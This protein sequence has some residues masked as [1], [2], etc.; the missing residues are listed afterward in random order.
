MRTAADNSGIPHSSPR[1]RNRLLALEARMLFDGAAPAVVDKATDTRAGKE[2]TAV[3]I[4]NL[5]ITDAEHDNQTVTLTATHGK[6]AIQTPGLLTIA[7]NNTSTVTL[8]GTLADVNAALNGMMFLGDQDFNGIASFTVKTSDGTSTVTGTPI[9]INLSPVNDA[10]TLSGGSLT[11]NE[12]GSVA[13]D[14]AVDNASG[15]GFTDAQLGL[16]DVDNTQEQVI[17]KITGLAQHGTLSLDGVQLTVG[18]TFSASQLG[19]LTYTHDGTQVTDPAGIM[20]AITV[21]IDDGAGGL[22]TNQHLNVLIKPVNQAP[23]V[24]GSITVIEGE[25]GVS[26]TADGVLL[27]GVI[28]TDRGKISVTD[29]DQTSGDFQ[30]QLAGLPI[31]GHLFYNGVLITDASF[32][33]T[34]LTK[35]TYSHDGSEPTATANPYTTD[36]FDLLVTDDGGGTSTPATARST[37]TINILANDNDPTL[38]HNVTQ[39]L[40]DSQP[41]QITSGMLQVSDVDSRDAT[42]T[43]TVTGVPDPN[44]GYFMRGG[45][46]LTVG[47][48]FTQADIDAGTITY[49]AR[50]L[51]STQRTD[52]LSFTVKDGDRRF[53]PSPRDGGIY[54][55]DGTTLTVNTFSVIVPPEVGTGSGALPPVPPASTGPVFTGSADV[56]LLE[57]DRVTLGTAQL[58]ATD[59][60]SAVTDATLTYRL[61]TLPSSG[62]L[63]LNGVALHQFDTFT[64]AD[65]DAGRL[66]F[67]H[68]GDEVFNESFQFDISDGDKV[69]AAKTFSIE[70]TPQNDT[71]V[72]TQAATPAV[73]E[74]QS[75][76]I[77]NRYITLSDSDSQGDLPP[78]TQYANTN[79]LSFT[80]T[81]NVTNGQLF[82]NGV[83]VGVGTVVTAAELDAGKLVYVHDG[84]ETHSDSFSLIPTDDQG[85]SGGLITATN[86][87]STGGQLTVNIQ[88][89]PIN[90][91]PEFV[92]KT[93]ATGANAISEGGSV[94]I[95]GDN[96]AGG[97]FLEYSDTD[98]SDTQRQYRITTGPAHGELIRDGVVLGVGSVFTQADLDAGLIKYVHDGTETRADSFQ[99]VVSDG[100]WSSNET[101][102]AQQGTAIDPARFD[103]Q[104]NPV[105][106]KPVVTA[107]AAPV[108]VG[109]ASGA[110]NPVGGFSVDDPDDASGA[111]GTDFVQITV[112]LLNADGSAFSAAEYGLTGANLQA[113]IS[114]GAMVIGHN[115]NGDYLV[116]QGTREQV[117]DALASLHVQFN[118]DG[119]NIEYQVQVIADDRLRDP[120]TGALT[121]GANGGDM[122]Q[123]PTAGGT[124]TAIPT[125]AIDGYTTAIP[126]DLG[127]NVAAASVVLLV[128][129][130][131]EPATGS[132]PT[133][134]TVNEDV[135]TFIGAGF[136]VGDAESNAFNLP[137]TVTLDT[138]GNGTLDVGGAGAQGSISING[139]S[140]TI[141]GDDTGTLVLTGTAQ[142]IQDLLN[143]PTSGLMYKGPAN[144]NGD[145][146]GTGAGNE[147]DVTV[148][149]RVSEGSAAIG[150]DT[151]SGSQANPD[152]ITH[153]AVTINPTNDAPTVNAGTGTIVADQGGTEFAV[154]GVQVG[155]PDV[156]DGVQTGEGDFVQV[157]VRLVDQNGVPFADAAAYAG[158]TISSST[159]GSVTIDSTHTG[160]GDALVIRGDI[161]DVNAYLA[162]LQVK[163]TGSIANIDKQYKLDVVVDDRM[164]DPSTGALDGSGL[165]NG[166]QDLGGGPSGASDVP[167]T[168]VDP[169]GAIAAGLT[170][171]VANMERTIF[172][173][174]TNDPAAIDATNVV[175]DES[176]GQVALNGHITVTD[177]DSIGTDG[178]P[179]SN[180]SATITVSAG[181][182]TGD[183]PNTLGGTVTGLG[184]TTITITGAT[185]AEINARLNALVITTPSDQGPGGSVDWNGSFQVTV[186]VNDGGNSGQRPATLPGDTN[187]PTA[188]PG[189]FSF[190]DGT[191]AQLVTTRVISVTVNPVN[192]APT[193][194]DANPVVLPSIPEDSTNPAGDTVGD[195]FGGKFQDGR[196]T[197]TGGSSANGFAGIAITGN[198]SVPG[199]GTWQYSVDGGNT[200]V[201][202]PQVTAGNALLLD[203]TDRIRFMP[204]PDF[205][206]TPGALD[207]R[208]VD[209]SSGPL[210]GGISGVDLSGTN[211]G[212]TTAFSDASNDVH[213]TTSVTA[214]N[215]APTLSGPG[216]ITIG[217]D[218][219]TNNGSTVDTILSSVYSDGKDNQSGIAGGSD[220]STPLQG[221]VILDNTADPA[222]QG[223]WQYSVSPG[224]WVDVPQ[225]SDMGSDGTAIFLPHDASLRFQPVANY[226][227]T[228]PALTFSAVDGSDGVARTT[229]QNVTVTAGDLG[230]S[231]IYS[232]ADTLG[233]TVIP[234]NDAP[235][236]SGLD[237][238]S[239]IV[240]KGGDPVRL[241]TDG[242]I[243]VSDVELDAS[244]DHYQDATLTVQ[245]QGGPNAD[246]VFGWA[247]GSGVTIAG[248]ALMLDGVQIG[249][250]NDGNGSLQVTFNDAATA[251][252]VGRVMG[253]VTYRNV[254]TATTASPNVDIDFTLNDQNDNAAGGGTAGGGQDQG[255]EGQKSV[256]HTVTVQVDTAPVVTALPP[257][258]SVDSAQV[259]IG[260]AAGFPDP[261]A[262]DTLSYSAS[263]LPAGLSIDAATGQITG[264]LDHSASQAGTGGVYTIT[265]TATDSHGAAS[266]QDFSLTVTNPA[267]VA[268][269]DTGAT[270]SQTT[271]SGNVITT[272]DTTQADS[273][274]DGDMLHVSQVGG[275]PT[276]VGQSVAGDNGGKFTINADGSYSFDPNGEFSDLSRGQSRTTSITYQVSDGEGGTASTTLTITVIAPDLPPMANPDLGHTDAN[277]G[278]SGNVIAGG[279]GA[280]ADTDPDGD[281]LT[282]VAVNGDSGKV[283]QTITGSNGGQFILNPD[284]TYSFDP[285]GDFASLPQGAA[286]TTQ[287]SYTVSDGHGGTSTTTLTVTVDGVNDA[288]VVHQIPD[289]SDPDAT[290][291]VKVDGSSGFT[292]NDSGDTLTYGATGLPAGLSIDPATGLITGTI[293]RSASQGGTDGAYKVTITATDEHGASASQTFTWRVTNPA[294]AAADDAGTTSGTTP[295][296]GN[297]LG[298]DHD[299]DGDPLA[300]KGFSI[301]GVDGSFNAGDSVVIAGVGTV[302]LNADGSYVFVAADRFSGSVPV[303]TYQVVDGQGGSATADLR[304]GVTPINQVLPLPPDS[305]ATPSTRFNA[306]PSQSIQERLYGDPNTDAGEDTDDGGDD[307]GVLH[308]EYWS[309]HPDVPRIG[310]VAYP[311]LFVTHAVRQSQEMAWWP[312]EPATIK[313]EIIAARLEMPYDLH[314]V[315]AVEASQRTA[316]AVDRQVDAARYTTTPGTSDLFND[317][318]PLQHLI[319][320]AGPNVLHGAARPAPARTSH[321]ASFTQQLNQAAGATRSPA[322]RAPAQNPTAKP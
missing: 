53:F 267:P 90:D 189:D 120:S 97:A 203:T 224:V 118:N 182:I 119:S 101:D 51:S 197:V 314:V 45:D 209:D 290:G 247:T 208:L 117:N 160:N 170:Q 282:V 1:L 151:G 63:E 7:G 169:Y 161:A 280:Q 270:D 75:V 283:G 163:F 98:N 179:G 211:S 266:S 311:A 38:T 80:I 137:V 143:D 217:E 194:T 61:L 93:D 256:T 322:P 305:P 83:L 233:A 73:S 82:L 40:T 153:T 201:V 142:D 285:H 259:S 72:A 177:S 87:T 55:A 296:Q 128:S 227:G 167:T 275:D 70:I 35:L 54:D 114:Q 86:H 297:V 134:A 192:D 115:G 274:P 23:T 235:A 123:A 301:A 307:G 281:S 136:A 150:S 145:L 272:A 139:R 46:R 239:P 230:G 299:P 191:S 319:R 59:D 21:N 206:G 226:N 190:A 146:N 79:A 205:A 43:Y 132:A 8:S 50:E 184:G 219:A 213:L 317:F 294:P 2:D 228:P 264:T 32:T 293:D 176:N 216:N 60:N 262:G 321:A 24:T 108:T 308:V 91:P 234:V 255:Q 100:D 250:V 122:N 96:S 81:G 180:L 186:V 71:P 34:D 193:R 251:A 288:P 222:T 218:P 312:D 10:P 240:T 52:T 65:I 41:L 116:L 56:G 158:V 175:V 313:S 69:T 237:G 89:N 215:D 9:N 276:H 5:S 278:T 125:D 302:T 84:S 121:T 198:A 68:S 188:N 263:G 11:V 246:D 138:G 78:G 28:D 258:A 254:S 202:I 279:N 223:K 204:A 200:W 14:A 94:V 265:V 155:D 162:G 88:V 6:L 131:N 287:I 269:A 74:G 284:G 174:G 130:T 36:S 47:S 20:D 76:V 154:G 260:T 320:T 95:H 292:D 31:H 252:D 248:T 126:A 207:V 241:D 25:T 42:L 221:I 148:S 168:D 111:G 291:G 144:A 295:L 141:T 49:V 185:L 306:L 19:H 199:Q 110:N 29:P 300:V 152:V 156:A 232:A 178:N 304:I 4:T 214:V 225:G 196:D 310:R 303:L 149:M 273:D 135:P 172:V 17:F 13:F 166:G 286:A 316:G 315:R 30:Y 236:F 157:T 44:T 129:E 37:I 229:V 164:R 245:R 220:T 289:R 298:N 124:P 105:N 309:L 103:I 106:D 15:A 231:S 318:D 212:G 113:D 253:A 181:T 165:A 109:S 102:H 183:G 244:P 195:L 271:T 27:P 12:G 18:S 133:T 249:T 99:Y 140:V 33:F 242:N 261:D 112:R 268:Q 238:G 243:G 66:Q 67:V 39:T 77:D 107:P 48:T 277:T 64:Q 26:L 257:Q 187:D 85:V 104:I 127:G 22:L 3:A 92:G 171:N 159:G 62:M 210:A 57:G 58:N 147:G 173:S 16:A